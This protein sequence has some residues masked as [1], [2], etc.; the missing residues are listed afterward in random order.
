MITKVDLHLRLHPLD[1]HRSLGLVE[2]EHDGPRL[3]PYENIVTRV[4]GGRRIRG[5]VTSIHE[6]AGHLPHVYVD[7]METELAS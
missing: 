4:A 2:I 7:D 5:H 6:R 3:A 1:E